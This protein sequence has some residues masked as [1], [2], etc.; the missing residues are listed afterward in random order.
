MSQW[1]D[2]ILQQMLQAGFRVETTASGTDGVQ[3]A[4]DLGPDLVLL[5]MD[6]PSKSGWKMLHHLKSSPDTRSIPV[7]IASAEDE[8]GSEPHWAR[9]SH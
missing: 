3:K 6:M 8:R 5:D 9:P 4:K 2:Q 1:R 7:I